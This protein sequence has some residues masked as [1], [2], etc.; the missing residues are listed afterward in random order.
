MTERKYRAFIS[1]CHEDEK[2]A[3]WLHRSL[4]RYR[5]PRALRSSLSAGAA[6]LKPIFRDKDELASG[7]SLSDSLKE[8]LGSSE[9][10][11]VVC[12]PAAVRS[13]WVNEEISTFRDYRASEKVLCLLVDGDPGTAFPPALLEGS[14]FEPLAADPR[15][16]ADGRRDALLRIAAGMLNVGFDDLRRR[17]QRQRYQDLLRLTISACVGLIAMTGLAFYANTQRLLA[18]EEAATARLVTQSLVSMFK[19]LSPGS[20][21]RGDVSA[22]EILERGE[23]QIMLQL[24]DEPEVLAEVLEAVGGVYINLGLYE[25]SIRTL[26]DSQKLFPVQRPSLNIR[27]AEAHWRFGKMDE[28][29]GFLLDTAR[30]LSEDASPSLLGD[31]ELT[32]G[33]LEWSRVRFDQ[34]E[35]HL[36]KALEHLES[37][38][39]RNDYR[40]ARASVNLG[41][42]YSDMRRYDDAEPLLR[43]G[44]RIMR[45]TYGDDH[46]ST[47]TAQSAVGMLELDRKH[48]ADAELLLSDAVETF[49]R[50][51]EPD[52]PT[53]ATAR[54][55]LGRSL[56]GMG[57][58]DAA[59]FQLET[60]RASRGRALGESHPFL[61]SSDAYRSLTLIELG[62]TE[63]SLRILEHALEVV[64]ESFGSEHPAVGEVMVYQAIA[65]RE[66]GEIDA[67]E[68]SYQEGLAI[69]SAAVGPDSPGVKELEE[70]YLS[71]P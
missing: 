64:Q 30:H 67:A 63:E 10:L 62:R 15:D 56:H 57:D 23:E 44:V 26:S 17:D 22:A 36:S 7:H 46:I 37:A 59:L 68:A 2:W 12:S 33:T 31:L 54:Q 35:A 24:S 47:A 28:A 19:S 16:S 49:E 39:G 21:Q 3:E 58:Y 6:D 13:K 60:A 1:Y 55:A 42:V 66:V 70:F 20:Q 11:V 45:A 65:L 27:M 51:L 18:S 53:L 43:T 38:Y 61:A 29:E 34:A 69:L 48:Y 52:H 50:V 14:Q 9:W 5:L 40:Y 41:N 32:W 8:A 25:R 4:E 71:R